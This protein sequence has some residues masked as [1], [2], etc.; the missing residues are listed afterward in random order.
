VTSVL[1]KATLDTMFNVDDEQLAVTRMLDGA[2]PPPSPLCAN[3]ERDATRETSSSPSLACDMAV[4]YAANRRSAAELTHRGRQRRDASGAGRGRQVRGGV[5]RRARGSVASVTT[6]PTVLAARGEH[7]CTQKHS[8]LL[9]LCAAQA[10]AKLMA[11]CTAHV[12]N[13]ESSLRG[14]NGPA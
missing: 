10:R 11:A 3:H 6:P 14:D 8:A 4:A 12:G 2:G 5:V 1:D 13:C 9:Y 7:D